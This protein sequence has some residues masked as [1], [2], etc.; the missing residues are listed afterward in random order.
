MNL[1]IIN[2]IIN[3]FILNLMGNEIISCVCINNNGRESI[4]VDKNII[5]RIKSIKE[6]KAS[7][8]LE[9]KEKLNNKIEEKYKEEKIRKEKIKTEE[10]TKELTLKNIKEIVE[11]KEIKIKKENNEISTKSSDKVNTDISN[12]NSLIDNKIIKPKNYKTIIIYGENETGKTSFVLKVC[13]NKFDV[14]YIPSFSDEKTNKNLILNSKNYNIE[15]IVSNDTSMIKECDLFLIFYDLT[16][17]SS[18][19]IAKNLIIE[20]IYKMNHPI[21]LIGNKSDLR[22][23]INIPDLKEFTQQYCF[24]EFKIS[25]KESIGIPSLLKKIGEI[26]NYDK[27]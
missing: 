4:I 2:Q 7:I 18:Y 26:F 3:N 15:F 11:N 27:E 13:N 1:I 25:I 5:D 19:N 8:N 17:L 16:S 23:Q 12:K 9:L 22:N 14:F 20:K 6:E 21:F 10:K 24:E